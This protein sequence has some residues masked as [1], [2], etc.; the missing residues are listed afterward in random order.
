MATI[1]YDGQS[2]TLAGRRVWL[3]S[4]AIQYARVPHP[5]WRSRIRAAKQAG[6]NCIDTHVFWNLHEQAPGKFN[7]DGDLNLQ[8]FVQTVGEEGMYCIL[9]PGPYIGADCDFGGLPAWLNHVQG[10]RLRQAN[11]PFLEACSRY[12]GAVMKQVKDLQATS[13]NG[14]P[15]VMIGAENHWFCDNPPQAKGY[16]AEI[17]R[18]LQQNGADVPILECNNLWSSTESTIAGW[19]GND[20]LAANLR[21]LHVVGPE[22]PRILAEYE[23]CHLDHWGDK[24]NHRP[25]HWPGLR[26]IASALAVGAQ[27][28]LTPFHGGTNFGFL[29]GRTTES[30]SSYVTT[31]HAPTA[32]LGEA[33]DRGP[34]YLATKRIGVFASQFS[35]LFAHLNPDDQHAAVA[36]DGQPHPLSVLHQRGSQGQVIFLF[37]SPKAPSTHTTV[38]L[39]NGLTLPVPIGQDDVAWVVLEADLAGVA[40]LNYTNLR[41][42]AFLDRQALVVFGPAGADGVVSINNAV[43]WT[44]VPAGKTPLI[45]EHE[46]LT[47]IVLNHEQLDAAYI[48][49]DGLV[50]GAA[51]LDDDDQPIPL[52]GWPRMTTI[53][54]DGTKKQRAVK[55]TK[56]PNTPRLGKWQQA[57][58]TGLINGTSD[59]FTEIDGPA[60]LEALESD[61]G[62]GWYRLSSITPAGSGQK[63]LAVDWADRSHVYRKGKLLDILGQGPGAQPEPTN[64]RLNDQA[65]V[66]ADNLGRFS[67]GWRMAEPKGLAGHLY[68]VKQVKPTGLKVLKDRPA[69]DLFA[70]GGFFPYAHVHELPPCDTITWKATPIGKNPLIVQIDRLPWRAMLFANDEPVGAYDPQLSAGFTRIVLE[71]GKTIAAKSNVLSLALFKD[72][73]P[74]EIKLNKL[75]NHLRLY[76]ATGNLTAKAQWSF[77]KWS[78]PDN[79]AFAPLRK[80]TIT[81]PCWYRCP[82]KVSRGDTPLWL[83][84]TGMTKGQIYINGHNAGRYFVNTHTGQTVGPQKR[85]YLPEPWL[86]TDAPNDLLIFDEHGKRPDQCRLVYS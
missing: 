42:W 35:Q 5:L 47:L 61:V 69:P 15:I 79:D 17:T 29:G 48:S 59:A 83:E 55:I 81:G 1:S 33:A 64:L 28:N 31:S 76:Q 40:T 57:R 11:G 39:P 34:R 45:V 20:N 22:A 70:L 77:A 49:P 51:G 66:L 30:R 85:Y 7:F 86:R 25:E 68:C 46:D 78:V 8:Q 52:K 13:S 75:S 43:L 32:P 80:T 73:G 60:S 9:R 24:P 63:L 36:I 56:R 84:P 50:I 6:L 54:P 10:V 71:V 41:P 14:G 26:D 3:V 67:Q 38:L 16:L 19:T 21:Q 12:L 2:L 72:F 18:Y 44:Q 53:H 23:T 82:F 65:V 62:Y 37:N 58:P 27:V 74:D 4:G